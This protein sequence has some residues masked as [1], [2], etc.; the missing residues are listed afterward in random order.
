MPKLMDAGTMMNG[1]IGGMQNFQFSGVRTEH[2][3]ATEYTAVSIIVDVTG[4]VM[5]FEN[6][7]RNT[8][9]AAV[10]ACKKSPRSNNLLL[11]TAIFSTT[12]PGHV[13]EL[14]GFKPLVDI[15]PNIDY[16]PFRP[17]GTTPLYDATYSA[18]GATV[19]YCERLMKDD[20]LANGIIFIVTDGCECPEPPYNPST[21]TPT[22]I[23]NEIR[24]AVAMEKLESLVTVLIGINA[25]NYRAELVNFQNEAGID[26]YIDAGDATKGKLAKLAEFVSQSVSSQSQALG[27]GGPSQNIAAVI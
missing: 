26:K 7:L 17:G 18:V 14:H 16:Q 12:Q 19:A 11:R 21:A 25:Q 6:D 1:V 27:T 8:L 22:M 10:E 4:S 9:I 13:N 5:G 24:N 20:F 2:L 15:D 3:G 23:K